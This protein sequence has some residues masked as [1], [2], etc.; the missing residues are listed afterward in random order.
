MMA[1]LSNAS[2]FAACPDDNFVVFIRCSCVGI[3]KMENPAQY[4]A[5]LLSWFVNAVLS[6]F[7]LSSANLL[8]QFCEL[9]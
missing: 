5:K 3:E 1:A 7:L 6:M 2:R 8:R 4:A 9:R